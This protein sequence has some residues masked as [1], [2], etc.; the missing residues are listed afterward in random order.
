MNWQ[1]GITLTLGQLRR[2]PR[3]NDGD[4][5]LMEALHLCDQ[6][7]GKFWRF[8]QA[9]ALARPRIYERLSAL[10]IRRFQQQN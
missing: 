3:T 7:D 1:P 8:V 9:E 6:V 10:Y 5:Q 2:I 4:D